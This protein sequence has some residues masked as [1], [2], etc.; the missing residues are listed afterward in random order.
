MHVTQQDACN[1]VAMLQVDYY[2][3]KAGRHMVVRTAIEL[4]KCSDYNVLLI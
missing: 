1:P 2:T 4:C 3:W